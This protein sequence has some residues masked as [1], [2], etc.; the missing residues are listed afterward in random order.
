MARSCDSDR[1]HAL[2]RASE[3][4]PNRG[5]PL[6]IASPVR[7]RPQPRRP[8]GSIAPDI[9]RSAAGFTLLEL[10]IAMTI[11]VFLIGALVVVLA[12]NSRTRY[13][14]EKSIGQIQ[15]ARYALQVL[16][17][18]LVNAGFYGEAIIDDTLAPSTVICANLDEMQQA[19][20]LH[21]SIRGLD[22]VTANQRPGCAER[23]LEGTDI[24]MVRRASTCAS[25]N[26]GCEPFVAGLP[27]IQKPVCTDSPPFIIGS[28]AS[29]FVGTTQP[30]NAETPTLA[31]I[32]RLQNHLYYVELRAIPSYEGLVPTLMRAE[33][34]ADGYQ[35]IP[36]AEGIEHLHFE[37]GIDTNRDGEPDEYL[38]AKG[39]DDGDPAD[40]LNVVA[41]RVYLIARNLR[42]THGYQDN[43]TYQLGGCQVPLGEID[44][45]FKRQ[46]YSTT[47]RLNNIAGQ[48]E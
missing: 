23:A 30:C 45:K 8:L 7:H 17:D 13:E 11:G 29:T 36:I 18:D 22:N 19:A 32:Y 12:N 41:V 46:A 38:T 20:T 4:R 24:I 35:G 25:G 43:R 6:S 44:R 48:R 21:A 3:G 26:T 10:M 15:N 34:T 31:P 5:L 40:W 16:S 1:Q 9:R 14:L 2:A 42:A 27:H 28:Q 39:I 37:Y 33:L 47:V